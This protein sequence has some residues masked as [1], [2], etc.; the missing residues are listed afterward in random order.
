MTDKHETR[1]LHEHTVTELRAR[2]LSDDEAC[3]CCGAPAMIYGTL[4]PECKV[5]RCN[6]FSDDCVVGN[7]A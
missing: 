1:P 6:R 5:A 4:C 3:W 7:D 2:G